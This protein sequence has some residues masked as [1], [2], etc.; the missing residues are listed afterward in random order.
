MNIYDIKDE[1]IKAA[2]GNFIP[3][4]ELM[5]IEYV[6][7]YVNIECKKIIIRFNE[8]GL[9]RVRQMIS[10]ALCSINFDMSK[11]MDIEV[12]DYKDGILDFTMK[13]FV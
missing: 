8:E 2:D 11:V 9:R 7:A 1:L 12:N 3:L 4:Y 13:V 6:K 10:D 5:V